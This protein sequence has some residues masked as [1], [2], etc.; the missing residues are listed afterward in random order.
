VVLSVAFVVLA[1]SSCLKA[2]CSPGNAETSSESPTAKQSRHSSVYERVG[3]WSLKTLDG[4]EMRFSECK[5]RVVFLNFWATWCVPCV[6]EM[7]CIQRLYNAIKGDDI[8]FVLVTDEKEKTVRTFLKKHKL[9]VPI[10]LRDK[11]VPK[12]F[13]T[14]KLPL[15]FILDR[16][17]KIV[18]RRTGFAEWDEPACKGLI[19]GFM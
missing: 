9:T 18:Y 14:K 4:K 10:Y 2:W 8:A 11:K 16:N 7:A 12:L 19:Q 15:T 17:G 13:K 1:V 5:G 3:P 6:A